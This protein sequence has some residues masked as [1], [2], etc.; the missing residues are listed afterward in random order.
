MYSNVY[1]CE[2]PIYK[3]KRGGAGVV[4]CDA[5]AA[6]VPTRALLGVMPTK[7]AN[8]ERRAGGL[9]CRPSGL[10]TTPAPPTA[11]LQ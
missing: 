11:T 9:F 7:E 6:N 1:K 2:P 8:G 4:R 3:C 10:R 5:R